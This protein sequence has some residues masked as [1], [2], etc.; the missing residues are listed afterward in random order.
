[1]VTSISI[2]VTE[3]W[4]FL[5]P[6][7]TSM[8]LFQ[9]SGKSLTLL[10]EALPVLEMMSTN[11]MTFCPI[12]MS[13]LVTAAAQSVK[14]LSPIFDLLASAGIRPEVSL[15]PIIV[16]HLLADLEPLFLKNYLKMLNGDSGLIIEYCQVNCLLISIYNITIMITIDNWYVKNLQLN[17]SNFRINMN[18]ITIRSYSKV[19]LF[20]WSPFVI[21]SISI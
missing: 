16:M 20:C 14:L 18:F 5:P 21:L 10:N 11:L 15:K 3:I 19:T 7:G 4:E 13:Y 8:C 12:W 2:N 17:T 1:M 9:I 6:F